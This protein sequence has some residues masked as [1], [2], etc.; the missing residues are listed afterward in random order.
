MSLVC[1]VPT[2]HCVPRIAF[3]GDGEFQKF[4]YKVVVVVV[5]V[6]VE[7]VCYL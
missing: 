1:S 6:V 7:V 5:V 3:A 4:S 2:P